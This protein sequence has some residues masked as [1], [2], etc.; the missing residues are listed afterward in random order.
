MKLLSLRLLQYRVLQNFTLSFEQ[1]TLNNATYAIDLIV[2]VNGTGKSTLLR[3]L[4]ELFFTLDI[5]TQHPS[6]GFEITYQLRSTDDPHKMDTIL[7]SN[8][9]EINDGEGN[10][11]TRLRSDG[12]FRL[13]INDRENFVDSIDGNKLP[14]L[15]VAFT[16]GSE[17]EWHFSATV[18]QFDEASHAIKQLYEQLHSPDYEQTLN[19]W[20]QREQKGPGGDSTLTSTEELRESRFLLLETSLLPLIIL[21]GMLHDMAEATPP[22]QFW[23]RLQLA[24]QECRIQALRGFSLRLRFGASPLTPE[25]QAFL[26]DLAALAHHRVQAGSEQLLVFDLTTVS[27]ATLLQTVSRDGLQLFQELQQLQKAM[28]LSEINL[29]LERV[30]YEGQD[31]P[32]LHLLDWLSDGEKS[33]LGRLCLLSLLGAR[34][35][36]ILLDEPEVHFNDYWKRRLL[37]LLSDTLKGRSSHVLMTTHSSITLT[38]VAN[39][40]IWILKRDNDYTRRAI[41]PGLRTLG[42]DPSDLLVTVFGAEHATGAQSVDIIQ[43]KLRASYQSNEERTQALRQLLG[44]VGPGYWRFLI[45]RELH[46]AEGEKR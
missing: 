40:N 41:P 24:M 10:K 30:R 46:S 4:A 31:T 27:A 33:F 16:T 7:I 34:E 22:D 43:Q 1:A 17:R 28:I 29:F 36:L 25:Q 13:C 8:L 37:M 6:F 32:P 35:A 12:L 3:A 5:P 15:V 45:R 21:C 42:A 20:Y 18:Q 23:N 19:A 11:Q 44:Q 38:D 14:P 9:E 39:S 2:G 26:D